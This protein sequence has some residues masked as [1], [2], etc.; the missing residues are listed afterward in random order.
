MDIA[1]ARPR[2][3]RS[4]FT[5]VEL[6][7]VIGIIAL[8][9]AILLPTLRKAQQAAENAQ[10]LSNLRQIGQA[11]TMYRSETGRLP[12]FWM[13]RNYPWQPVAHNATGNTIWWTSFSQGGKTT[14]P[15]ISIGYM[16]D[17]DKPLNKYLYKDLSPGAWDGTKAAA[18]KR[19]PRDVWRCPADDVE[20]TLGN[21]GVGVRLNYLGPT[22]PSVHELLGTTYQCNR[23]WM[24]DS[25]IVR[26]YYQIF[27]GA[28]PRTHERVDY[29]NRGISRIISRWNA[30]ETYVAADV[31]FLWSVFYHV[32]L[33]GAHTNQ[34]MH[35][36][37]F[38]DGHAKAV[39]ISKRNVQEW[40]PRGFRYTP[41]WGD[42]W[43]EARNPGI[44]K[45]GTGHP[46]PPWGGTD[47]FDV[48]PNDRQTSPQG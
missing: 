4:A 40:G 25:E 20:G 44:P 8:L 26:L 24:Y 17:R 35:N 36:G 32:D 28:A 15:T 3:Q 14:H 39:Y 48:G 29:F 27:T 11:V 18:E 7:V 47:P 23:G 2:H 37:V 46:T 42:G 12:F 10:C 31:K 5:L 21:H 13:L 34:P 30:S 6:L 9:V 43:R 38:L 1:I 16:D 19:E 41:K 22:V 33:P 45:S